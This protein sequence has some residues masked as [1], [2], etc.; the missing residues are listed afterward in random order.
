MAYEGVF[1]PVEGVEED[2]EFGGGDPDGG[3]V[4]DGDGSPKEFEARITDIED[5]G[6]DAEGVAVFSVVVAFEVDEEWCHAC[7]PCR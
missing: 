3:L 5:G 1:G 7:F 6:H 4:G 2:A